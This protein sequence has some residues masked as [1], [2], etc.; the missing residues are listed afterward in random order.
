MLRIQVVKILGDRVKDHRKQ[1]ELYRK[2]TGE[3]GVLLVKPYKS[4]ILPR[5]RFKALAVAN[6]STQKIYALFLATTTARFYGHVHGPQVLRME[7]TLSCRYA[8]NRSGK[9]KSAEKRLSQK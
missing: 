2:G 7:Y 3:Q 1:P 9:N 4:E 5:W 6:E 8:N